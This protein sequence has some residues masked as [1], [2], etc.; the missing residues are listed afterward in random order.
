MAGSN[1]AAE[2]GTEEVELPP[3][4]AKA[5]TLSDDDLR[6]LHELALKCETV[7]G[8]DL[9]IEWGMADGTFYVLQCRSITTSDA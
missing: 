8:Q 5:R 2:G 9:D 4:R 3:E 6:H 7:Y 1:L